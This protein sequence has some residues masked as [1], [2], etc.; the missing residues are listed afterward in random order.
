MIWIL[1]VT[2]VLRFYLYEWSTRTSKCM[3][4]LSSSTYEYLQYCTYCA[5]TVYSSTYCASVLRR[6]LYV[7]S[8]LHLH[9]RLSKRP[10][11]RSSSSTDWAL[12][13]WRRWAV[14]NRV[15]PRSS[16]R[17][18]STSCWWALAASRCHRLRFPR[19]WSRRVGMAL[20]TAAA[21]GRSIRAPL[22]RFAPRT[23][24]AP[25]TASVSPIAIVSL[26]TWAP[27][28]AKWVRCSLHFAP[29]MA[30]I[31]RSQNPI[32]SSQQLFLVRWCDRFINYFVIDALNCIW[33]YSF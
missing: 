25:H 5:S 7:K 16:S 30:L 20:Q 9:D 11:R 6:V 4:T 32:T 14:L 18:C 29:G 15:C 31:T 21:G 8:K 19:H 24:R 12:L 2:K 3:S 1:Y 23:K 26:R 22:R 13:L 10:D 27:S 33:F 28:G 17:V